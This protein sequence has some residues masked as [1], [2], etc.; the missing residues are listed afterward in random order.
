[1]K[2]VDG[3]SCIVL[4]R[5]RALHS[6]R[7]FRKRADFLV[8]GSRG[9]EDSSLEKV[10]ETQCDVVVLDFLDARWFPVNLRSKASNCSAPKFLLIAMSSNPEQFFEAVRGGLTGFL[11]KEASVSDVVAAVR[12]TFG[13]AEVCPAELCGQLFEHIHQSANGGPARPTV[14][15]PDRTLRQQQLVGLVAKGLTN[16]EIASRLNIFEYTVKNHVRRIMKRVDNSLTRI[17]AKLLRRHG[18]TGCGKTP[19]LSFRTESAE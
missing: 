19:I 7:I 8:L 2:K 6:C 12:S 10:F 11:L 4:C 9:N 16:K 14:K 1:M 5:M 17:F 13:G 15:R 3:L 18:L